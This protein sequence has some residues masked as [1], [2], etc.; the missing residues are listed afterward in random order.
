M[1]E[2]KTK[3]LEQSIKDI[4]EKNEAIEKRVA[5]QTQA[6]HAL[7]AQLSAQAQQQEKLAGQQDTM[8]ALLQAM[9]GT[10]NQLANAEAKP[11]KLAKGDDGEMMR[12]DREI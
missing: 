6:L 5:A 9:Q 11:A 7:S 1:T 8:M 4:L 12:K 3:G 10:L 2:S